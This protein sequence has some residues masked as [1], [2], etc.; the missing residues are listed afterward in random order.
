MFGNDPKLR[1][2]VRIIAPGSGNQAP[3][4]WRQL[5]LIINLIDKKSYQM[6][7]LEVP[8]FISD[9]HL[10]MLPQEWNINGRQTIC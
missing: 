2:G 6:Y 3:C 7:M 10:W 9:C 4:R 1:D 5:P 8:A